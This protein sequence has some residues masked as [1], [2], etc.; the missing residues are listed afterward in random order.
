VKILVT[1]GAGY[2]G[3][4][5][6][7]LLLLSGYDVTV[8]DNFFYG[9]SSLNHLFHFPKLTVIDADVRD[10]GRYQADLYDVDAV[11]PLAAIVGAPACKKDPVTA[12]TV[13]CN[14]V[15]EL[16][17]R[18]SPSQLLVMPTSNSAYGTGDSNNLCDECSEL[19][20]ISTYAIQKVSIEQSVMSRENSI[21]LRLATVFGMSPRMRLDLLVNDF[22]YRAINDG[23]LV[24]YESHFVRNYIHVRDVCRGIIMGLDGGLQ[25]GEIYNLGLSEAN[26]SK[27]QL[28]ELVGN[29]VEN[30]AIIEQPFYK[31]PDQ[32]NYIVSNKKIER[33]GFSPSVSIEDGIAEL[34]RGLPSLKNR[35]YGNI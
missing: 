13:N 2:I 3:S 29:F 11:V 35:I 6:V 22:V 9:Q 12:E 19:K 25:P 4:V 20:P 1:G 26:L 32:R 33:A 28:A 30:L 15:L 10:V 34:I 16:L 27:L 31:D 14:S 18:L 7:E 17:D 21:S 8:V 23:F 5:L 24:L